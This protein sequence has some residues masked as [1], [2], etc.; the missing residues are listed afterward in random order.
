[1]TGLF[2]IE[3]YSTKLDGSIVMM[4]EGYFELDQVTSIQNFRLGETKTD[5]W[6]VGTKSNITWIINARDK[7]RLVSLLG[8]L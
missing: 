7:D 2:K 8:V 4:G 6:L 5:Y 1:V 3:Y